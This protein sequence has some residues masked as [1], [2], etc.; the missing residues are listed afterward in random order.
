MLIDKDEQLARFKARELSPD[1]QFKLTAED[2][3][4]H[5]Q[6]AAYVDAMNDMVLRTDTKVAPWILIP[7]KDKLY[8]RVAVLKAFIKYAKTWLGRR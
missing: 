6:F 1:K 8:A 7:G 2:W 4:N 3:R 5:E